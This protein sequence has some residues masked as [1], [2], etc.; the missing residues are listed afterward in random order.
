[1]KYSD[2]IVGT[3]FLW[4]LVLKC[5]PSREKGAYGFHQKLWIFFTVTVREFEFS[6]REFQIPRLFTPS[7]NFSLLAWN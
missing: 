4:K 3:Y 1:M 2:F 5:D 6:R 7:V